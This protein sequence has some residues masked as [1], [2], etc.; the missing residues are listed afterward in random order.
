MNKLSN[1]K[2]V[3]IPN[4]TLSSFVMFEKLNIGDITISIQA[5]E[6][7]YCEPRRSTSSLTNEILEAKD[8]TSFEVALM[9][10]DGFVNPH[11][12]E[13]LSKR[14]WAKYWG[15]DDVAGYVPRADVENLIA[16]IE[17]SFAGT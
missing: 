4:K 10:D 7:H 14:S 11:E 15:S 12:D 13:R 3:P 2:R 6:F 8:Y 16:D 17:A 1:L 5:S 9:N